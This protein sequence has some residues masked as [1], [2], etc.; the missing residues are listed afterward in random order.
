MLRWFKTSDA[1][2]SGLI[3]KVNIQTFKLIRKTLIDNDLN[4]LTN[5]VIA[6]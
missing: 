5:R 4:T 6:F 3:R 1:R 2:E